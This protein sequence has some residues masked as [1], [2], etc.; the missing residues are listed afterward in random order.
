MVESS[1]LDEVLSLSL[2]VDELLLESDDSESEFS[3]SFPLARFVF[4][5]VALLLL[6]LA[7]VGF[8]LLFV[9]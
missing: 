5:A 7:A 4:C 1:L 3:D 2:L 8:A 6:L 9:F